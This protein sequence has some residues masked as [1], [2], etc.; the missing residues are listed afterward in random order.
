MQISKNLSGFQRIIFQV[1]NFLEILLNS[2][3]LN[4]RLA[5]LMRRINMEV[6]KKLLDL[7]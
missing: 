6:V 4:A 7:I 1:E 5:F 3:F 2:K